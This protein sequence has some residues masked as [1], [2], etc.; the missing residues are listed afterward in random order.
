MCL[1]SNDTVAIKFLLT[2]EIQISIIPFKVVPLGSH[3]PPEMLLP[4]LVAVLEVF[5]WKCPQ[6]VCHDLLDVAHSSKMTTFE[7]ESEFQEKEKVTETQIRQVWGLQDH[8]NN[9]FGQKFIHRDD[10][11]TGSTVVMQYPSACSLWPDTMNPFS[12]SFKD[13]M[14]VLLINCLSLRHESFMN[15]TLTVKKTNQHGYDF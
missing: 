12:E 1:K 14:I 5:M 4:L 2:A 6:L 9:L 10:S 3:T 13:L 7:V 8:W 11:V 15:N